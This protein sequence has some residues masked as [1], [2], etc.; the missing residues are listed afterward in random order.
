MSRRPDHIPDPG[1][2]PWIVPLIRDLR[3]LAFTAPVTFP[4]GENGCG[5]STLL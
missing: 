2:H 4:V 3:Q 5:K 1:A